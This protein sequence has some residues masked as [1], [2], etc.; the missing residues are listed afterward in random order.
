MSTRLDN[1]VSAAGV[2]PEFLVPPEVLDAISPSGDR[3]GLLLGSGLKGEPLTISVL[4]NAPTRIVMVG[5]LYLARQLALRAMASGATVIV[6][7]GRPQAWEVL[8]RAAGQGPD[9]RP[10]PAVQIRR[11]IPTELDRA[12]EDNPVLIMHDGGAV[13]QELFPPRSPWQTTLYVLPY[14]HPHAS[15]TANGADLILLQRLPI[16]QAHLAGRIWRLAP[17]MAQQLTTLKDDG[18]IALGPNLWRPLRLV[19]TPKEQQIL[20]PV[21]RGD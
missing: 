15:V 9:G 12:T 3:G 14:L 13:P 5:G 21:R 19:T 20:G 18:V 11:L 8:R 16:G 6:S 1:Q 17:Q 2:A 7:T 10:V 4:R